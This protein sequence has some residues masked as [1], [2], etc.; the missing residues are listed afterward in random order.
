MRLISLRLHQWRCYENCAIEFPDGLIGVR[1]QNGSGKS[2]IAEAI[3]WALFGK[4]RHR[5]RVSDL[6]RQGAPKGSKSF[7]EFEFQ[8]GSSDYRV[9][10]TVGGDA[11]LWINGQLESQKVTD[12]NTRIAQE[13]DLTWDVFQRTVFAQQKD[14]AA[15]DPGATSEARKSHVERL[16]GLERFKAAA[17]RSRSD[18]RLHAA[19]LGAL[20]ES[21]PDPDSIKTELKEAEKL[22]ADTDPAVAAATAALENETK[23]RNQTQEQLTAEQERQR[24]YELLNQRKQTE[25]KTYADASGA[26]AAISATLTERAQQLARVERLLPEARK[27]KEAERILA[28]WDR[29]VGDN[30]EL[31]TLAAALVATAYDPKH[32]SSERRRYDA[33]TD[34]RATL[35]A[36]RPQLAERVT[37]ARARVDA[38]H[39]AE[40]AGPLE[41]AK[42]AVKD[43]ERELAQARERQAVA[44][45]ELAHDH[46]HL[47]EVATGGPKT[48]CPVCKKP[49]GAEYD[50]ILDGYRSRITANERLVPELEKNCRRLEKQLEK[51]RDAHD[52]ARAAAKKLKDTQGPTDAA[53]ARDEVSALERQLADIDERLRGL[54]KEIPALAKSRQADEELAEQWRALQAAHKEKKKAVDGALKTLGRNSFSE[55]AHKK[56]QEALE[57]ALAA[58][59]KVSTLRDMTADTAHLKAELEKQTQRA[60]NASAQLETTNEELHT[61]AFDTT[62][63]AK[64][65]AE[66]TTREEIREAAQNAL[67]Q[68]KLEAQ[69]RSSEV[70]A[71]RDRLA[72]ATKMRD[73][74]DEKTTEVRHHEVAADLL[75]KYRDRQAK[76]AWP[77]LEQVASTLLSAATDG[78]YADVKLSEDYRPMIVDRGEDHEL[79]RFSGGEQDLANLCLR[80]AIADWVSKERN[81][82]L[83]FVVLDEV[84]GS[85][86]DERRQRLLTELRALSNRF[87]QM[88]VITHVTEIAEL[89]D[90]QLEVS[91]LEPGR[92]LATV[93]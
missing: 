30:A 13:L 56:A 31:E 85:Q 21:A 46:T 1:G 41:E 68:A 51:A 47:D 9:E 90:S 91:L 22:A 24:T 10:R 40:K 89:C 17:A 19:E 54:T 33:L 72:E 7:V 39:E 61:L 25:E 44:N 59:E 76:R 57:R 37:A 83:G 6:R 84:F 73:A 36:D 50:D 45:A 67:T 70:K 2:T 86:D 55:A 64:L 66:A 29:L 42:Q 79:T 88:L 16:L 14:V 87:R 60:K 35:L 11:K 53:S 92:S 49:Y 63:P 27:L 62:Q 77:R 34:E 48:P 12:T 93:G 78:R 71:L 5:A 69:S 82:D 18:M 81:V 52:D 3:G 23:A 80:L 38:L 65:K 8:L 75:S 4:R 28:I 20:R 43:L 26:V 15:L 58:D 74:I 32:A